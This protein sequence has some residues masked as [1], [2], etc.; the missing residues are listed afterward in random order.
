MVKEI[1]DHKRQHWVVVQR[2]EKPE[3]RGAQGYARSLVDEEERTLSWNRRNL[4]VEGPTLHRLKFT[5][6]GSVVH[7]VAR[8]PSFSCSANCQKLRYS[9]FPPTHR[10]RELFMSN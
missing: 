6:K 4:Q 10:Q 3:T 9:L 2:S 7:L 1:E 8:F 5:R